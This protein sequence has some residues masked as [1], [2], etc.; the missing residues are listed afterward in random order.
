MQEH[1]LRCHAL[2]HW[3]R[4][5][6]RDCVGHLWVSQEHHSKWTNM[7]CMCTSKWS[8]TFLLHHFSY[9]ETMWWMTIMYWSRWYSPLSHGPT[10]LALTMW[11]WG[12]HCCMYMS[13][14]AIV[15][16]TWVPRTHNHMRKMNKFLWH[17][18][19]LVASCESILV[20]MDMSLFLLSYVSPLTPVLHHEIG[21]VQLGVI[22]N[23]RYCVTEC[24]L[25]SQPWLPT[26]V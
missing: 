6:W 21:L 1:D 4:S 14:V 8:S 19:Y 3:C 10:N 2:L 16:Y 22:K 26:D 23:C 18:I 20:T 12:P 13:T 17:C 15:T 9:F 5:Y 24:S 25:T 7:N 11:E